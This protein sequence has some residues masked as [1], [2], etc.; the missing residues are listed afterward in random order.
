MSQSIRRALYLA[1]GL[2]YPG[3]TPA[4]DPMQLTILIPRQMNEAINSL[5]DFVAKE[6]PFHNDFLVEL[7]SEGLRSAAQA[8]L[9]AQQ[10]LEAK[11][12]ESNRPAIEIVNPGLEPGEAARISARLQALRSGSPG[13]QYG[14]RGVSN[15]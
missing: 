14:E 5:S 13:P 7:L 3:P 2:P 8:A 1:N 11:K 6:F 10:A 15:G 9:E 12:T 4:V